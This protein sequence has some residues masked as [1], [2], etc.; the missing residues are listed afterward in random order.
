MTGAR[1]L[2]RAADVPT[3]IRV[4]GTLTQRR[5]QMWAQI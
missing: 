1:G 4:V 2:E 3:R 5:T